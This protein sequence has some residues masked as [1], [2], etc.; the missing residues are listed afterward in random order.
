MI[1][2]NRV[3]ARGHRSADVWRCSPGSLSLGNAGSAL[4]APIRPLHQYG[5]VAAATRC[6]PP[7][8]QALPLHSAEVG[9][10]QIA[11]RN[12]TSDDNE[13]RKAGYQSPDTNGRILPRPKRRPAFRQTDRKNN[14]SSAKKDE[15]NVMIIVSSAV[16]LLIPGFQSCSGTVFTH[17]RAVFRAQR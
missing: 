7:R 8:A 2:Y 1:Q 16:Q 17:L 9:R 11:R 10:G 13:L 6:N 3:R 15:G 5:G 14:T 12:P 4:R